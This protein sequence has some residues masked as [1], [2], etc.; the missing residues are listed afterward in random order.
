MS[1]YGV[2][3]LY[4]RLTIVEIGVIESLNTYTNILVKLQYNITDF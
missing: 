2:Y 4:H 1:G 3:L